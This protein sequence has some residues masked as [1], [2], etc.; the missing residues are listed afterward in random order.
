MYIV[1]CIIK[2]WQG[3][4]TESKEGKTMKQMTALVRTESGSLSVKRYDDYRT[5]KEFAED[6][7][8]VGMGRGAEKYAQS[9]DRE[10]G[11]KYDY[12]KAV[13]SSVKSGTATR[14]IG[15]LI[16]GSLRTGSKNKKP[17]RGGRKPRRNEGG[18]ENDECKRTPG[19]GRV[20]G[21]L[22]QGS[23]SD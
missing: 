4:A 2:A 5:Q 20:E 23:E 17:S 7:R 19:F 12:K 3:K 1:W 22:L 10:N 8:V 21:L 6:L 16:T 15:K 18:K 14:P 9:V 11:E 13:W